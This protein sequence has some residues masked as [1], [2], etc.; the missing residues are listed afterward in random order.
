MKR[1]FLVSALSLSAVVGTLHAQTTISTIVDWNLSLAQQTFGEP[2]AGYFGQTLTVPGDARLVSYEFRVQ[3]LTQEPTQYRSR[4][5]RWDMDSSRATGSPLYSSPS[6]T[7]NPGGGFVALSFTLPDGG[8]DLT[9]GQV[10]LLTHRPPPRGSRLAEME[11]SR[12]GRTSYSPRSL[13]PGAQAQRRSVWSSGVWRPC[14]RPDG[15]RRRSR[16]TPG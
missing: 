6:S 5:Y 8:I 13:P 12:S 16:I 1:T 9:A 7:L 15:R 14:G 11:T 3:Q 2:D 10:I 4:V